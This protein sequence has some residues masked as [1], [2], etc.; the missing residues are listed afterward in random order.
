MMSK[1]YLQ[2]GKEEWAKIL[3]GYLGQKVLSQK[4]NYPQRA[5][6]GLK[7]QVKG[8][9]PRRDWLNYTFKKRLND[10]I[11]SYINLQGV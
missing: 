9:S 8:G 2:T 4:N 10:L 11:C 6:R 1:N 7:T 3:G 5:G